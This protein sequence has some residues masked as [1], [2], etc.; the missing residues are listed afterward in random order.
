MLEQAS[1]SISFNAFFPNL[2]KL[3]SDVIPLLI[4]VIEAPL[5]P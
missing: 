4:I 5:E 2:D 1:L 3:L